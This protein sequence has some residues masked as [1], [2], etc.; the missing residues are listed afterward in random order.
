MYLKSMSLILH[1]DV[2]IESFC[3]VT[4]FLSKSKSYYDHLPRMMWLVQ[5]RTSE[6]NLTKSVLME[7][8]RLES[9]GVVSLA[10]WHS[11]LTLNRNC[12]NKMQ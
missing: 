5:S 9:Q 11:N 10:S 4:F 7:P 2:K 8:W 3:L 1:H 6:V 12:Q